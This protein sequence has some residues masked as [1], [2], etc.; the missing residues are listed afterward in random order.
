MYSSICGFFFYHLGNSS[1]AI[2]DGAATVTLLKLGEDYILNMPY[3]HIKGSYSSFT[4]LIDKFTF[5][6]SLLVQGVS[7]KLFDIWLNIEK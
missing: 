4:H 7:K 2:L 5:F 1:S 3:A 6:I